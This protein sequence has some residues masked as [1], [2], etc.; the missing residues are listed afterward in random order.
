VDRSLQA[1][2]I[3]RQNAERHGVAERVHL[4][5]G[6]LL[7]AVRGPLK[8]IV[9]NLPYIPTAR[10]ETLMPEVA[11]H[12]PRSALDGGPDGLALNRR[13]LAQVPALLAPGGLLLLEMDEE[14]GGALRAAAQAAL[15]T[16]DVTVVKDLAGHDR[17][18]RVQLP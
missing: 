4:L 18:L 6:G 2:R 5:Q 13:L 1:L 17:V 7:A 15:P 16:A 14:Q 9:A 12:E 10:I 3:A 11:R 8:L